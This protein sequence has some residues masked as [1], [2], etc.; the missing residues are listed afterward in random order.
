ML[1]CGVPSRVSEVR[2]ENASGER[3]HD[4]VHDSTQFDGFKLHSVRANTCC[5]QFLVGICELGNDPANRGVSG[6]LHC[7]RGQGY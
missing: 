6:S 4:S 3:K 1:G 5:D 2:R 7:H